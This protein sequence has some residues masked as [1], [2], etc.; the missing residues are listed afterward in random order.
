M[1]ARVERGLLVLVPVLDAI[2]GAKLQRDAV[3]AKP[4]KK[5]LAVTINRP[6]HEVSQRLQEVAGDI[7][8]K[9]AVS[10]RHAPGGRGTGSQ[11]GAAIA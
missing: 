6:L 5:I 3:P 7:A 11:H 2:A 8:E 1:A 9:G 10:F 4:T